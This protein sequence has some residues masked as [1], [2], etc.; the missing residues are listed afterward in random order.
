MFD[1][2]L[3]DNLRRFGSRDE[4]EAYLDLVGD[5]LSALHLTG[6]DPR[7]HFNPTGQTRFVLPLTV[8][9]RYIVA[10]S[11]DVGGEATWIL[12]QPH[13][14]AGVT[15]EVLH[16]WTF[17]HKRHDP[18]AGAPRLV[19]LRAEF[20]RARLGTLFPDLLEIAA[21]ELA[22]CRGM[23]PSRQAHS[24]GAYALALDDAAR[25]ARLDG[26]AFGA[27]RTRRKP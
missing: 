15:G 4:A 7:F 27:R 9:N 26:V 22:A 10:K 23:T 3:T 13:D 20:V 16:L 25:A 5:L 21:R 8:N 17:A 24:P 12:A 14:L 6:D 11:R 2:R 19:Q 1:A 18:P